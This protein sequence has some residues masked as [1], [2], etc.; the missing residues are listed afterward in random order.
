MLKNLLQI[1]ICL[2]AVFLVSCK[3]DPSSGANTGGTS[4]FSFDGAP[5]SCATPVIAGIYSVG[6]PMTAANTLT[7]SVNVALK[8]T[9]IIRTTSANGVYF[10]GGGTF[11]GTGPQTIVLTGFGTPIRAENFTFVPVTN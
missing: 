9:Y 7:F 10:E 6:V 5:S 3:K 2:L 4:S 11:S 8:G 1:S